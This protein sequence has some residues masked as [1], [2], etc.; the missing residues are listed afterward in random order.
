[1][2]IPP[3]ATQC[4]QCGADLSTSRLLQRYGL[5]ALAGPLLALSLYAGYLAGYAAVRQEWL[6]L[7]LCGPGALALFGAG[8]WMLVR[9]RN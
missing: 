7:L 5:K 9:R 4:S 6:G 2:A 8:A 1:M 3:D